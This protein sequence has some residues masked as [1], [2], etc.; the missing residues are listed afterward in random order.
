MKNLIL[1]LACPLFLLLPFWSYAQDQGKR[2]DSATASIDKKE[3][4]LL[5][6]KQVELLY[7]MND[8]DEASMADDPEHP[9][10]ELDEAKLQ[11]Q[12]FDLNVLLH[13]FSTDKLARIHA[14][15]GSSKGA[16]D[17]ASYSFAFDQKEGLPSP[18]TYT[19][20]GKTVVLGMGQ[21]KGI[22]NFYVEV[23]LES[24][25]GQL[26]EARIYSPE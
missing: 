12:I 3:T 25:D 9:E 7:E 21:V 17:H 10:V 5:P 4:R 22:Q 15:I 26:S 13:L 6:A 19:R 20:D 1:R 16:A 11:E 14:K 8:L 23:V 24:L 18:F 2:P